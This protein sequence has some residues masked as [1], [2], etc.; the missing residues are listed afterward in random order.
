[1][2]ASNL[3]RTWCVA[4][5]AV[6]SQCAIAQGSFASPEAGVDNFVAAVRLSNT[7]SLRALLGPQGAQLLD[8]GDAEQDAANRQKFVDSYDE[9]HAI[10]KVNV[11]RAV[12]QTGADNWPLPIAMLQGPDGTWHFDTRNAV[13]EILTRRIGR[14]ELSAIQVCLAIVDA[15]REFSRRDPNSDGIHEYAAKFASSAGQRDGLYWPTSTGEATS[16]LGPLLIAAAQDG[17]Q[18]Q[19][20]KPVTLAPYHGYHYK[21]LDKQGNAAAGGAYRYTIDGKHLGGFALLAYPARYG[22]SG[23]MS[24]MVNQDGVVFERDLGRA[25]AAL[26]ASWTQFNP[27][28]RWKQVQEK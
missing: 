16:P 28:A 8:S 22:N 19:R 18:R 24:F 1:M 17:G 11:T 6:A 23:V 13:A 14:N 10:V 15:Q 21:F 12:L 20:S 9:A 2:M 5:L 7:R 25:T 27:D 3:T 4:W 26:A